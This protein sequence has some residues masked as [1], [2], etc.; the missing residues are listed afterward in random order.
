M[1]K[2]TWGGGVT[3]DD[4]DGAERSQYKPYDGP[5]PPNA[6]YA[7]KVK[8]L[9][10]GK[11]QADNTKLIIGLEL[12]PRQS[13]PDE[14]PYKGYFVSE[15]IAVVE[16]MAG[17]LG[18]FLDAIGV[19]SSDFMN[20]TSDSG[21]KDARG[22]VNITKIGK[23]INNGETYILASLGDDSYNGENRKRVQ[24][25]WP[26]EGLTGSK[27]GDSDEDDEDDEDDAPPPRKTKKVTKKRQPE[28]EPDEDEDEDEDDSPPPP[29]KKAAKKAAKKRK[30][31]EPE[32]DDAD[33]EDDEDEDAPF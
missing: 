30:A 1:G 12:V 20:R 26:V 27:S 25:F 6:M 23:W 2:V 15:S 11:S 29:K 17:K 18:A 24:N 21:E 3:A 28:P 7:W 31:P 32:E 4:I 13:R 5:T 16:S 9:K 33:D 14:K 22:N 10:K 8:I 19:S